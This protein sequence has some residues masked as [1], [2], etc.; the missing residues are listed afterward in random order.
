[1]LARLRTAALSALLALTLSPALAEAQQLL[2][3]GGRASSVTLGGNVQMQYT[4]SSID[5][6]DNDFFFRRARITVDARV[7]DFLGAYIQPDFAPSGVAL[8]DA[9][10]RLTFSEGFVLTV[11]QFKR[12]FDLFQLTSSNDMSIIERDGRVEGLSVCTGV[13]SV[14]SYTRF[15]EAL[16]YS[17]RDQ[18]IR[19]SGV[20][21]RVAYQASFTNGT[22]GTNADENDAKSFAGRAT[23]SVSEQLRVSGQV[24]AHDYVDPNGNETAVAFAGDVEYGTWRDG[25]HVQAAVVSGDNWEALDAGLNPATFFAAQGFVSYYYPLESE[26]WAGVE[27]LARVSWGDPDTDG[28][29]DQ[30]L[31]LTP[32]VMLYVTGRTKI[33]A[34]LDVYVPQAGDTEY[35]LKFL[36]HVYF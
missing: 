34:N 33:G 1:M 17:D 4:L 15:L 16:Q 23:F 20:F 7:N 13:S 35:S 11:G 22:G 6:A 25:L 31:L 10:M 27:P 32:G 29:D 2:Q 24:A 28:D 19:A 9:Y 36:T 18:G 14:C 21:G 5:G 26:R 8:K 3:V 30:G 12:S